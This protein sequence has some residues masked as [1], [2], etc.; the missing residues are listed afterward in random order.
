LV[1]SDR[2]RLYA[3]AFLRAA[4]TGLVGVGVGLH[5]AAR[6]LSASE[7]GAVVSAGLLGN[8]ASLLL[9][10]RFGDRRGRRA[11]LASLAALSAGGAWL[12]STQASGLLLI[13]GAFLGLLNGMGRDRGASIAVEQSIL[14][15]TVDDAGRTRVFA[16]YNVFQDAGHAVG[17][18]LAGLPALQRTGDAGAAGQPTPLVVAA[19]LFLLTGWLALKLGERVEPTA[20][21]TRTRITPETRRLVARI[22]SLF[23]L[24]SLGGGFLTTALVSFFFFE[25]FGVGA[26]EI[27]ALFFGARVLNA[28]S[29][30]GAAWLA[31][32]FGLVN[33]MVFTHAPSSLLLVSA[34]YAPTFPIA[35]AFFL[36]R[37]G[38]VEMDVPTR[39]S[40]VV[41][42]VR[43]EE[44]AFASGVT[45]LVRMSA[46]AVA[47]WVAGLLMDDVS[48]AAPLVAGAALKLAYDFALYR[49][50][51]G[52][53]PPEET[54]GVR[55]GGT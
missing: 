55:T 7:I 23:V 49:A 17:S 46:W 13:A 52:I 28:L 21:R 1:A 12:A 51:R 26:T 45:Q 4:A 22:S 16:W 14:P 37:E 53:R 6:G 47:P 41:A 11:M 36:L 5:L 39:Q 50:F 20:S 10:T 44:R 24:D 2:G 29:H 35:A 31:R 19:A 54:R 8:A 43:P 38:L 25:R 42:V 48:L 40:Y 3:C 33:T 18:L 30:L 15:A 34:A 32:R 9:V 27:G